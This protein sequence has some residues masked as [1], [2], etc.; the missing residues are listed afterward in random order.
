M[1]LIVLDKKN[2]ILNHF[3]NDLRDKS[4]Q[5]DG[6]RFR[7][8]LS[9]IGQVMAY[10]I[11]TSMNYVKKDVATPLGV[12]KMSLLSSPP[13]LITI[14]R[15]GIPFYQGFLDYFVD[16]ESGFMAAER[17]ELPGSGKMEARATYQAIPVIENRTV[18][19]IDPMLATGSS[20]VSAVRLAV[21]RG[22]ESIHIASV[23]AAP[24][25]VNQ[26]QNE[27]SAPFTLWTASLD[28]HLDENDYIVPGLGDAGDLSYGKR[29]KRQ[30]E[31]GL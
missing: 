20:I 9:R 8:S 1:E 17:M 2:S 29:E 5:R 25:G 13:T 30:N 16:A 15:A 7:N 12:K 27:I 26:I 10:E 23:I 18:I 6:Y 24:E 19:I 3:L 11:S 21:E 28:D 14:F 31:L 22:P 4:R